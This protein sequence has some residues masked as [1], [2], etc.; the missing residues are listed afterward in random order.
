MRRLPTAWH[1]HDKNSKSRSM[2]Q[3]I[4]RLLAGSVLAVAVSAAWAA[5]N[6]GGDLHFR[7]SRF[8]VSGNT[9]LPPSLIEQTVAPYTGQR[10]D[11]G[12]VQ[13]ALEALEA[14]YRQRRSE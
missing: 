2:N 12:D 14:V 5:D 4:V 1:C 10:R 6:A 13:R 9:L 7:S 8:D 3:R 11:F